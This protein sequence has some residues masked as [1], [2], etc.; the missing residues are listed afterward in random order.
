MRQTVVGTALQQELGMQGSTALAMVCLVRE[1]GPHFTVE[2]SKGV[3]HLKLQV[4]T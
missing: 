1:A 4:R 3:C 2:A